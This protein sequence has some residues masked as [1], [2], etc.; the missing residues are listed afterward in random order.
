MGFELEL[1]VIAGDKDVSEALVGDVT[2][3][4]HILHVLNLLVV[5]YRH[6]E[7]QFIVLAAIEGAG[8]NVHVQLLGHDSSLIVNGYL[9]FED[10]A[11][12]FALLADVHEL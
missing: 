9:L 6:G 8:G 11:T 5:A 12:H 1:L 7:Q 2:N 10:A 3:Q 4:L